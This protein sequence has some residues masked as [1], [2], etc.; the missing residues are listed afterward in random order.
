MPSSR[1]DLLDDRDLI[2]RVVDH[3][4]ARQPDL[5]RL[6]PQQPRAERVE[7]REPDALATPSPIS[8]STRSRISCAA[9]L[10]NVTAST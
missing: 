2:G 10:V 7:R 5:R 3:E 4:I 6:A 8:A 1:C 9:L